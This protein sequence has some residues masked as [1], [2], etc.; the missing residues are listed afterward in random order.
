M[1]ET[2]TYPALKLRQHPEATPIV[3]FGAA[4][5][6]IARWGGV[7]QK[8][9]LGGASG[10]ETTG[11]QR[12]LNDRRLEA[13]G[14]FFSE[15]KNVIQNPLLCAMREGPGGSVRFVP[16]DENGGGSE[17]VIGSIEISFA[18]LNGAP[19][20]ELLRLARE[21]LEKRLP[22]LAETE[23]DPSAIA[24]LRHRAGAS[25]A[26]PTESGA[27]EELS[28]DSDNGELIG[29]IE[30]ESHIADFWQEIA[31]RQQLLEEIGPEFHDETFLGYS[32]EAMLSFLKPIVIVDGQH[33]LNGALL[34]AEAK[35]EEDP[36]ALGRLEDLIAGG[37]GPDE[38]ALQVQQRFARRLPVSLL[39]SPDPEEHVFQFV[40]VNQKATPIGRALLGTIVSTTLS[41]DELQ[42]V[43]ERLMNAGIDVEDSRAIA[44][45]S[46]DER[47]PFCGLVEKGL[48]TEGPGLLSWSVF[49][50][51]VRM[52][53]ELQ[54]GKL[55][56]QRNDYADKWKREF[57]P[58]SGI[59]KAHASVGF[60]DPYEFWRDLRGPWREVFIV[61]WSAVRDR[62]ANVDDDQAYNYW[63]NPRTSN[64]F[65]KISL[66]I[67][68]AD[69]FQFLC[70]LRSG[71]DSSEHVKDLV[72]D[73]LDGVADNYFSRDWRLSGV[74]KDS[75]IV[76]NQ[77]ADLWFEYRK[78]PVRL[79][80]VEAYA[81]RAA[82]Q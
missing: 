64:L 22:S 5:P 45:L 21:E 72:N 15:E 18:D 73:W 78:D 80:R 37:V 26:E 32:R 12:E 68:A 11:F 62:F 41:N 35:V 52:F 60:A 2:F 49:G 76:R 47:S 8:A 28:E 48:A 51:I 17:C 77:W 65:N 70:E 14:E 9:S 38:A 34:A 27:E 42:S 24:R 33:R 66:T 67:L 16:K 58:N 56:G 3:L 59:I 1:P 50:S 4:A 53:R 82:L 44:S 6:E 71:I 61:F 55:F 54:G 23:L 29:V 46:R 30:D 36:H 79:P 31:I 75:I 74:K 69:Y 10:T 19:L 7:P 81:P 63:G 39:L 13:L 25:T 40:I 57:L 43:Q 20:V